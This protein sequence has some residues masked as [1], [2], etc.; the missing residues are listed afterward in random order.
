M[1]GRFLSVL[2]QCGYVSYAL[3]LSKDVGNSP[4]KDYAPLVTAR[5]LVGTC[6]N[7]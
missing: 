5:P 4:F 1:C 7:V 6:L 3:E 2:L